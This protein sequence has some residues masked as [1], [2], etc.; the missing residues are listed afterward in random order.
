LRESKQLLAQDAAFVSPQNQ[1]I[2]RSSE[3]PSSFRGLIARIDLKVNYRTEIIVQI[4]D[5]RELK[6]FFCRF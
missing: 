5:V 4:H 1:D 2:H 6:Q 3:D